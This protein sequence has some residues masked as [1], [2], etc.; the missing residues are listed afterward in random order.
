MRRESVKHRATS[1]PARKAEGGTSRT[2]GPV[3]APCRRR[4][5]G[6]G[7]KQDIRVR[8]HETELQGTLARLNL[9]TSGPLNVTDD[10]PAEEDERSIRLSRARLLPELE[11]DCNPPA[12]GTIHT[13]TTRGCRGVVLES[14]R[15]GGVKVTSRAAVRRFLDKLNQGERV[16]AISRDRQR[17]HRAAEK[18]LD[19]AGIV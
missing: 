1:I 12:P 6:D 13:W 17:Q 15:V 16:P 8:K 2:G 4:G 11:R 3:G 18:A 10:P 7:G 9:Y 19:A 5:T 14:W